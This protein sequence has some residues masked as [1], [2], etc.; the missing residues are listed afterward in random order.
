MVG[1]AAMMA[2]WVLCWSYALRSLGDFTN[3]SAIV[4]RFGTEG[5]V[6]RIHSP[7]PLFS[8]A[9]PR[10][11]VWLAA[12]FRSRGMPEPSDLGLNSEQ[13]D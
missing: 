8:L 6:V 10:C 13:T 5:S 1:Q 9:N 3:D 4:R 12:R 2:R 11:S 7:R